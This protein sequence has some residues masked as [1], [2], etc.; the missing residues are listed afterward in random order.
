MPLLLDF[1]PSGNW[2][3]DLGGD[4]NLGVII[5][6][7]FKSHET[8]GDCQGRE[9]RNL[10]TEAILLQCLEVGKRGKSS[11]IDFR[12]L[13]SSGFGNTKYW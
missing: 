4:R 8:R 2:R 13:F 5:K 11:K 7:V 6:T 3:L 12:G 10:K 1:Y 9:R